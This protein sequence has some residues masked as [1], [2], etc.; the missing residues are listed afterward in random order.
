MSS[1][2]GSLVLQQAEELP[3]VS[4]YESWDNTGTKVLA[5]FRVKRDFDRFCARVLGARFA[6]VVNDLVDEARHATIS[7]ELAGVEAEVVEERGMLP[8]DEL[9]AA[10]Q[11][12]IRAAEE[13]KN[14]RHEW[15]IP[16]DGRSSS[17]CM[18]C[19]APG[20]I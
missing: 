17:Y 20:D 14:H 12:G 11:E 6:D 8:Y 13:L 10:L 19:M 4:T 3:F 1:Y 5:A 18:I 7:T 2:A 15:V 9:I 16:E